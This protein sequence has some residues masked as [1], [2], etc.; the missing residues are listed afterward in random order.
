MRDWKITTWS[1]SKMTTSWNDWKIDC[2]IQASNTNINNKLKWKMS[3]S[4]LLSSSA[5]G[6]PE[7]AFQNLLVSF[8]ALGVDGNIVYL[9]A[10]IKY[11][12]TKV[13]ALALDTKDNILLGAVEFATERIWGASVVYFPSN[14]S[15][16]IEP[17]A[18]VL[19]PEGM[20]VIS[21]YLRITVNPAFTWLVRIH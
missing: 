14:I 7:R 19:F 9:Q 20:S 16:Y 15:R 18:S 8:P 13:F 6:M 12:D 2:T 3:Q 10:R 21:S 17:E 5:R 1:N 11:M 4:G